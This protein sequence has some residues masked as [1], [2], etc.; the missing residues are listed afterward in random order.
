MLDII[1][2]LTGVCNAIWTHSIGVR[3]A[4]RE[5]FEAK[6]RNGLQGTGIKHAQTL[7]RVSVPNVPRPLL[8]ELSLHWFGPK[9]MKPRV[10]HSCLP[11]R[12]PA[13]KESPW[14]P[15]WMW[16]NHLWSSEHLPFFS[17]CVVLLRRVVFPRASVSACSSAAIIHES[18]DRPNMLLLSH[19]LHIEVMNDEILVILPATSYD[20]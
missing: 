1:A 5:G 10:P 4:D 13:D 6:Y 15:A 20:I 16:P 18:R 19:Q 7:Q 11:C 8:I 12:N 17:F 3:Q 2:R 14:M 9:E